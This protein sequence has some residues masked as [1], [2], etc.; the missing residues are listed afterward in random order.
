MTDDTRLPT[1]AFA[2][3]LAC[4]TGHELREVAVSILIDCLCSHAGQVRAT[5]RELQIDNKELLHWVRESR[6]SDDPAR[7]YLAEQFDALRAEFPPKVERSPAPLRTHNCPWTISERAAQEMMRLRTKLTREEALA[8]LRGYIVDI[9]AKG[10]EKREHPLASGRVW[11]RAGSPLRCRVVVDRS[12][13]PPE[14]VQV[15]PDYDGRLGPYDRGSKGRP[16]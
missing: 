10:D 12:T 3:C 16:R 8:E 9:V 14:V 11:Y 6:N 15:L 5:A 1:A 2:A 7:R 13:T 4:P